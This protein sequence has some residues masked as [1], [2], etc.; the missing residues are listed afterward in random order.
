MK[1]A[2]KLAAELMFSGAVTTLITL[3]SLWP[4]PAEAQ[5]GN[6]AICTATS[7][8][9]PTVP[10]SSFID[11]GVFLG[12]G[13]G[14]GSDIC[15]ILYGIFKGTISSGYTANGTV[16]DT[17]ALSGTALT[18]TK[19]SPWSE[20]GVY[21]P[22]P[23]RSTILLPSG[24]I[25]IPTTWVLPGGTALVG[26][27]TTDPTLNNGGSTL[28]TTIQA[29]GPSFSGAML[30]F[31]DSTHCS[32]FVCTDISVEH[33]TLDGNNQNITGIL[34]QNSQDRTYANHVTLYRVLGYG[35][36]VGVNTSGA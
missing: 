14:K 33:L 8:C 2:T 3:F 15:D 22:Q 27:E 28:Q 20:N 4:T 17:R 24:I 30:Q 16:I 19:G 25:K 36:S 7:L 10:S 35:L 32:S 11:A 26:Q 23:S 1:N 5:T 21:V 31:G 12:S 18:C 13:V 6:N 29:I 9:L 34:N